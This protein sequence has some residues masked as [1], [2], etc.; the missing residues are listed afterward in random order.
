MKIGL[1]VPQ[2]GVFADPESTRKVAVAAEQAGLASLWA[3]D[4]LLAPVNPRT[5]YPGGD[6]SLPPNQYAALDPLVTLTLAAA[7][8]T[9][10]RVGTNILVAPWYPPALLARSLATLDQVSNGRLSIGLGLGWSIDEYDAV[11]VPK[12]NLGTRVEEILEVFSTLWRDGVAELDTS[13]E[14]IAPSTVTVKPVQS[15]RP[16]ILLA[17]FNAAGLERIARRADGWL[18]AGMPFDVISA[19]WSS[20]LDT[21][22]RYGRDTARLQLVLRTYPTFTDTA[23]GLDREPFTG[24]RRQV[25]DDIERAR[26]IGVTE[27]ILDLQDSSRSV[28]EL[29]DTA[30]E[31]TAD[32][33][34]LTRA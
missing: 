19:M 25:I 12:R 24:N 27:L 2:L 11:G 29:L 9:R 7:V 14:H 13:R 10:I 18:P 31:L 4:R 22:D 33:P 6:G 8:T 28:A 15:P 32:Q 23:L 26:E 3:I 30:A 21:A 5:A 16:P 17:S 20:V 34:A 1:G